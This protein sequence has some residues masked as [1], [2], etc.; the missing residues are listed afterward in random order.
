VIC[1][2]DQPSGK[3][4]LHSAV[5]RLLDLPGNR[6]IAADAHNGRAPPVCHGCDDEPKQL[7]GEGHVGVVE[8]A[9]DPVQGYT[10]PLCNVDA[11]R[12][13]TVSSSVNV[14]PREGKPT[15]DT[16]P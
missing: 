16:M 2:Q 7:F 14:E 4:E 9:T 8:I 10:N 1:D 6:G 3:R 5:G 13:K 12:G 11:G 15:Q